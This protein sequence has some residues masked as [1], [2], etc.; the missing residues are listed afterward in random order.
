MFAVRVKCKLNYVRNLY[1]TGIYVYV[2]F[3]NIKLYKIKKIAPIYGLYLK[4]C[5]YLIL[6]DY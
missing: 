4:V 3:H 2:L 5:V 6:S 1:E